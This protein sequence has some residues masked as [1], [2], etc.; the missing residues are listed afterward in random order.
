MT[1]NLYFDDGDGPVSENDA[2]SEPLIP[3]QLPNREGFLEA[4]K[5]LLENPEFM[6]DGGTLAFGLR[7]VYPIDKS[8]KHVYKVLKGSDAVVYQGMRA[9]GFDPAL[10]VYYEDEYSDT[11]APQ[12]V[13]I[14]KVVDFDHHCYGEGSV[15]SIMQEEGGIPVLQHGLTV[16]AFGFDGEFEDP[17]PELVEWVTPVTA[18]NRQEGAFVAY[19]NEGTK[20]NLAYGDVCMVVRMGKAGDRLAYPTAARM[21]R[22]YLHSWQSPDGRF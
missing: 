5:A 16:N 3:P 7:H 2:A 10:Y 11:L 19:G 8:L 4:F 6:A 22:E 15:R 12:G 14:D 1:Y 20:L 13:M 21:R 17:D 18:Y 9:L